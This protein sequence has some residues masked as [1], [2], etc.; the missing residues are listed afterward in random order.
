MK[1]RRSNL[2]WYILLN[3]LV[4]AAT[5][6][7]VIYAWDRFRKD[8]LPEGAQAVL[9]AEQATR[10]AA[11]Q[12]VVGGGD[13]QALPTAT[14]PGGA[15]PAVLASGPVIEVGAVVG[16]GDLNQEYVLLRRVGEGDLDMNG[17]KLQ[18]PRGQA[19]LFNGLVLF[20]GGGV[21]V[22]SRPGVDTATELFWS[23]TSAAWRSGDTV[24]LLDADGLTRAV[25]TI[26]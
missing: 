26:P 23:R 6:L 1:Q 8:P 20:K 7:G 4:S 15:T 12:G 21:Q 22:N 17:W 16:A 24:T 2:G 18:N 3:I 14:L 19:Y 13:W 9:A 5:T 11:Q 10:Q 25:F